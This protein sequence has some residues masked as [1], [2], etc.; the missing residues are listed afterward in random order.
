MIACIW[1]ADIFLEENKSTLT[2]ATKATHIKCEPTRNN[3]PKIEKI[4]D[5]KTEIKG[6]KNELQQA[7]QHIQF[8]TQLTT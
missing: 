1:P 7:N 5:L 8:M 6:L 3:D 4:K 2:Y